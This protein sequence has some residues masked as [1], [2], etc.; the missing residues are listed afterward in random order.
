MLSFQ[1]RR[2]KNKTEQAVKK[3]RQAWFGRMA[4]LF[5]RS[6]LDDGLWGELE[7][8]LVSADVGVVTSQRLIH[9]LKERTRD[10]RVG[11]PE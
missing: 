2:E 10:E 6:R 9:R 1:K 11:L 3:T 7:E 8:L 4:A 5:Q